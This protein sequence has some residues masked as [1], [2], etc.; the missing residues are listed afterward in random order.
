MRVLIIADDLTGALDSTVAL[1]GSGLRCVVA[2][3]VGD[4]AGALAALKPIIVEAEA[5]RVM[6]QAAG[7]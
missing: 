7:A 1:T 5:A 3:R 4:V 2:R 6:A